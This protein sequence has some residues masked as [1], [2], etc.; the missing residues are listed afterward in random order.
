MF[1][2]F[3]KSTCEHSRHRFHV[4]YM[5]PLLT[6]MLCYVCLVHKESCPLLNSRQSQQDATHFYDVL[7]WFIKQNGPIIDSWIQSLLRL[8]KHVPQ[9]L[10][11]PLRRCSHGKNLLW[12]LCI[13]SCNNDIH[14]W[15]WEFSISTC[16]GI[17]HVYEIEK[18]F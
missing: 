2:F 3:L 6:F 8:L 13:S 7:Q 10:L 17:E 1:R 16:I 14:F 5:F 12:H 15:N 18:V 11:C 9:M 4:S